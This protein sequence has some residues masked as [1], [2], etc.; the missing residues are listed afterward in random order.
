MKDLIP[1]IDFMGRL[2]PREYS[3]DGENVSPPI[4]IT[5][6]TTPYLALVIDD[7]VAPDR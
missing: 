5:I 2:F 3:C 7:H 6:V 4:R 1:E